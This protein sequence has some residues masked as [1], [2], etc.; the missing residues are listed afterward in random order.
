MADRNG[1]NKKKMLDL[2]PIK[3][4]ENILIKRK[5]VAENIFFQSTNSERSF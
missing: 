3:F 4:P 2:Q 1:K 5:K